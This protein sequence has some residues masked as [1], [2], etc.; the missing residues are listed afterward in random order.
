M[1]DRPRLT[2]EE[3]DQIERWALEDLHANLG[4]QAA[5]RR[6]LQLL[7]EVRAWRAGAA[8]A[9][10]DAAALERTIAGALR[11]AVHDH[12]P[13]TPDKIGSAAKRIIGNLRNARPAGER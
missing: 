11:S 8:P 3:L 5:A 6:T 2:T 10:E 13:I 1:T 12:G 4:K 9:P 7:E